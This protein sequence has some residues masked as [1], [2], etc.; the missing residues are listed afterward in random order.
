MGAIEGYPYPV[1]RGRLEPGEVLLLYTDGVTEAK[2]DR[3]LY[4]VRR[5]EVA[6]E[7]VPAATPG[8]SSPP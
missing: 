3:Q 8:V 5:L 7:T 6:L 2:I 1:D 4:G